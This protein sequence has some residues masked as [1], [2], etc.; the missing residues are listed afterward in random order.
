[1]SDHQPIAF[2]SD[3]GP[4]GTVWVRTSAGEVLPGRCSPLTWSLVGLAFDDANRA[5]LSRDLGL[6]SPAEAKEASFVGRLQGYFYL[7]MS[8]LVRAAGRGLG[9]PDPASTGRQAGLVAPLPPIEPASPL[10]V[11]GRVRA[12]VLMTVAVGLLPWRRLIE[13]RVAR[14]ASLHRPEARAAEDLGT[15]LRRRQLQFL[16]LIRTHH[17]IRFMAAGAMEQLRVIVGRGGG[18]DATFLHWTTGMASLESVQPSA[19]LARIAAALRSTAGVQQV[20]RAATSVT[21]LV[22]GLGEGS[23]AIATAIDRFRERHGHRGPSEF[24]PVVPT[25]ATDDDA[26]LG[27]LRNLSRHASHR[28][29][30]PVERPRLEGRFWSLCAAILRQFALFLIAASERSKSDALRVVNAMRRDITALRERLPDD[31]AALVPMLSLTELIAVSC[32][33]SVELTQLRAREQELASVVDDPPVVLVSG[34][35]SKHTSDPTSPSDLAGIG[36]SPGLVVGRAVIA[37]DPSTELDVGDI[38]VAASTDTAWTPLFL[39]A[40]GVVTELGGLASH[41]SIVAREL[42]IPAV[43]GVAGATRLIRA[44]DTIE[45]DGATGSVQIRRA[46]LSGGR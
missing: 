17:L 33:G 32:R 5:V 36:A 39:V 14:R 13:R 46:H 24:D 29:S 10:T 40:G 42:G 7:N 26:L 35:P 23:E 43:V 25:W 20:L 8:S 19:E 22:A 44:G 37:N 21:G 31:V 18:S 16:R 45:I 41:A 27:L 9:E 2:D 28:S 38:I 12:L 15:D 6:L 4:P 34:E 11:R 3:V 30:S 1:M